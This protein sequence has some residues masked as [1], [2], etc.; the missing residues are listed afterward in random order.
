MKKRW[1]KKTTISAEQLKQKA[2]VLGTNDFYT[3]LLLNRK[4]ESP[5]QA[6]I[7]FN[8]ELS[9]LHDPFSMCDMDKAVSRID[10]ACTNSE[11]VWIYGDY[12]VD[13]T[14]SVA[15]MFGFLRQFIPNINYYIPDREKEGY[16][17]SDKAVTQAIAQNVDL[18]IT[19]DCGIRSVDLVK[20]G[21][22][23]GVDFIICDHH[24]VGEELPDAVAVLDPKRPDCTYPYKSLSACGVGFK[25]TQALCSF[26]EHPME[27][28]LDS[29]DLVAVSIASDLVPITGENRVLAFHGLRKLETNPTQGLKT[30]IEKFMS[31]RSIDITNIVFMIGP[32]INAAGRIAAADTAV[33]LLLAED[34]VDAEALSTQLNEYNTTRR[35]LDQDIT[36]QALQLLEVDNNYVNKKTTVVFQPDW[37]KGVVGIVASRLLEKHY[38]PTIVLTKKDDKIVGSARSIEGFDIHQALVSCHDYLYQFGGHQFAAGL[39]MDLENLESFKEAFENQASHLTEDQLTKKY[40]YESEITLQSITSNLYNN[41][42]RFAPFGPDNMKPVF[43]SNA[44]F[45]TGS[46]RTMGKGGEHLKLNLVQNL[47]Q[48]A[49]GA[50]AFG[51]GNLYPKIKDGSTMDVL[52]TIEENSFRGDLTI[53][54]MIQDIQLF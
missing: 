9:D 12:D 33:K 7:F 46:A 11:T 47:G 39:T 34:D 21:Q 26:W 50:T 41:I 28:A 53:E 16:G 6:G 42:K 48:K 19:L 1:E 54:L 18:I 17:L 35:S 8:P 40:R 36:A 13:G 52:F 32:R 4:I 31:S 15:L 29:L 44:V 38:K 24:E 2:K 22:E 25:L 20:K 45:D 3:Q 23:G 27:L 5:D 49:I 14:T 37:H 51:F 43:R 30:I 10:Q